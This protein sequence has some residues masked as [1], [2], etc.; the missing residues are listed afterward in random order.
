M[1]QE[2]RIKNFPV[3]FFSIVMGLTGFIL[4]IQKLEDILAWGSTISTYLVYA[5][6]LAFIVI[7]LFYIAKI[8]KYKEAVREEI[9]NPTRLSFF[10]TFS[11]SLLL[12]STVFLEIN[13]SLSKYLWVAGASLHFIF[14]V[15][16]LSAW[17]WQTKFEIHHF[18]PAWFIPIVGNIL[19]PIAGTTHYSTEISWFFFSSGVVF[20]ILMFTIF[21]YRIFFHK[22]LMQKLLPTFFILIAPPS[23]AFIAYI[24]LTGSIDSFARILY[25]FALFI[26]IFLFIQLKLILTAQFYLSSWAYSFPI[27]SIAVAT[28][29]FYKLSGFIIFK[30]IFF[31][32]AAVLAILIVVLLA[33]TIKAILEK[34]I[35]MKEEQ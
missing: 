25:Y 7:T 9:N 16:I 13:V 14:T 1:N 28:S 31:A 22:P 24:K 27:A 10:P 4:V 12:L 35:C 11:I 34:V 18:S 26:T 2:S 5:S 30:Y 20:W 23:I 6:T 8:I 17:I 32:L 33:F 29:L 19:V 15:F 3:S 21:L